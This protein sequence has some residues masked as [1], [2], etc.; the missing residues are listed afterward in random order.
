MKPSISSPK[1]IAAIFLLVSIAIVY[2]SV[3]SES[4]SNVDPRE[5][6][7]PFLDLMQSIRISSI[8]GAILLMASAVFL[9][10]ISLSKRKSMDPYALHWMFLAF[11]FAGMSLTKATY[12]HGFALEFL[13]S[14]DLRVGLPVTIPAIATVL[15][16]LLALPYWKFLKS[17]DPQL[18]KGLFV[19]G[20][21]FFCG[22]ILMEAASEFFWYSKGRDSS[23]YIATSAIEDFLEM[24][25]CIIFIYAFSAYWRDERDRVSLEDEKA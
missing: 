21:V 6:G 3:L 19:G 8:Y 13:R 15:V 5:P 12:I 11:I 16:G 24:L 18:R 25:G 10:R 20:F 1:S 22:V 2:T 17:L 23:F 9:V 4:P 7:N 14:I